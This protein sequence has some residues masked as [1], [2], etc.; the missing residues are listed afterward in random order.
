VQ[1]KNEE[2]RGCQATGTKRRK[3]NTMNVDSGKE[4]FSLE[5]GKQPAQ[6]EKIKA[7]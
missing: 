4:E 3:K 2:K 1:K 6:I 5:K 7:A